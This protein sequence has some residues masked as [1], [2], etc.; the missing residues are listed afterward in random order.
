MLSLAVTCLV[1]F[2]LFFPLAVRGINPVWLSL[3]CAALMTGFTLFLVCGFTRRACS[4]ILGC[5]GGLSVAG[6]LAAVFSY[7]MRLS[8]I[9]DEEAAFLRFISDEFVLDFKGLLFA[10][11]IIGASGAAMDV[12]VFHRFLLG[13]AGPKRPR[14]SLPASCSPAGLSSAGT[15]WA[16]CPTR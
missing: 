2:G 3:L 15:L 1:V 8:G 12:A 6:I 14:T 5:L 7:S 10:A 13:R 16:P 9:V 11:I 4:A